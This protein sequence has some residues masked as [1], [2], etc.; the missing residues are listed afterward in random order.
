MFRLNE[1][2]LP[3]VKADTELFSCHKNLMGIVP[4]DTTGNR[5]KIPKK[6]TQLLS[7]L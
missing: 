5:W 2:R 6:Q 7:Y 1:E 3:N 4:L